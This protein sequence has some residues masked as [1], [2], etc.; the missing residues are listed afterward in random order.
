[1]RA[2]VSG[3][4]NLFIVTVFII[5]ISSLLLFNVSYTKAYRVKNKIITTYEQYEG[6]CGQKSFTPMSTSCQKMIESYEKNLGY[7]IT[8]MRKQ[9]KGEW[10][11]PDLGYCVITTPAKGK[12][13]Y[14]YKIR[15][16]IDVR[17]PLI[18][19][20]LGIGKFTVSG[21]THTIYRQ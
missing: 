19:K 7:S 18:D 20:I 8:N 5:I 6:N 16:E 15:T 11:D 21:E 17:F 2:S 12:N 10:C 9:E 4:V 14:K 1:M 13:A 3:V